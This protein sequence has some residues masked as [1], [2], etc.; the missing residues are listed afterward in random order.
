MY[1]KT[2]I[3]ATTLGYHSFCLCYDKMSIKVYTKKYLQYMSLSKTCHV[4]LSI[5]TL[6]VILSSDL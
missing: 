3:Y 5:Y 2:S 4:I 6:N 1:L